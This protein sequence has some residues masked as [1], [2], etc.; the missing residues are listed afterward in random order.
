[1]TPKLSENLAMCNEAA[2]VLKALAHPLRLQIMALLCE[3]KYHVNG[4]AE[5]LDISQ[6]LVSQQLRILRMKNLVACTREEGYAVYRLI[7]PNVKK[8]IKCMEDCLCKRGGIF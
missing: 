3:G 8:V 7:E 2:D 1:M 4:L 6:A 5:Q